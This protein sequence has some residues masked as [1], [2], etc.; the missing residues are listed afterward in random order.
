[1]TNNRRLLSRIEKLEDKMRPTKN[2]WGKKWGLFDII[3]HIKD[4]DDHNPLDVL[5][6]DDSLRDLIA[7]IPR[8][9]RK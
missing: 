3:A 9:E 2:K 8:I 5:P 6:W 4:P 7:K 1:M